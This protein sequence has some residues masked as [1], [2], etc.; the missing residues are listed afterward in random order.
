MS[1]AKKKPSS[2]ADVLAGVLRNTGIAA[3]V[4]QAGIIP[5]WAGLVG[6]QIATVTEPMSI[7]ADGTLFVAV[8]TNAWMTELSM[9][10]PEL[11]RAL[12][13]KEGRLAVKRIRW[14]LQRT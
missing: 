2:I 14:V 4:E 1:P 8:T 5:E 3:R 13:A 10:E 7:A 6:P 11:L 9:M 12:N